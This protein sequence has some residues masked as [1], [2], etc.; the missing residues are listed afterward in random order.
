[1]RGFGLFSCVLDG[2]RYLHPQEAALLCTLPVSRLHVSDVKAALCLLGQMAAPL[3]ALWILAQV[4]S[5]FADQAAL[6]LVQYKRALLRERHN[7]WLLPSMMKGVFLRPPGAKISG[8][9]LR[10]CFSCARGK[11]NTT[12]R[13]MCKRGWARVLRGRHSL[14]KKMHERLSLQQAT[15]L[16]RV[17]QQCSCMCK[18]VHLTGHIEIVAP[19][20]SLS[21]GG[22][23]KG[24]CC[25]ECNA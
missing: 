15:G 16:A 8:S 25:T 2:P 17:I 14:F 7:A 6:P 18:S 12:R 21:K 20:A 4:Q 1:M 19:L 5:W 23:S 3:H 11:V 22:R 13:F 10:P 24:S 9:M